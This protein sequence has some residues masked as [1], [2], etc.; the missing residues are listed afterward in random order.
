MSQELRTMLITRLTSDVTLYPT[1]V[2]GGIYDRPIKAGQGQGATPAAFYVDP[3][4]P[5]RLVRLRRCIYVMDGGQTPSVNGPRNEDDGRWWDSFPQL[6]YYVDATPSGR[7]A[8]DEI[9]KRVRFLLHGWQAR[10]ASGK[11]ATFT[12][13]NITPTVDVEAFPGTLV[14]Y[15]RYQAEFM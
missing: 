15:R 12:E 7:A 2:P 8:L 13:L 5:T 10:L 1:M 3:A 9:D 4:D 11:I 6:Y 14:C